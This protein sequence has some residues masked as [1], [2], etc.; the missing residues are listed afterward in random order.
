MSAIA[1]EWSKNE[2]MIIRG[3]FVVIHV[4][5]LTLHEFHFA[6]GFNKD[7]VNTFCSAEDFQ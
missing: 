2:F 5:L 7:F 6:S 3:H 1:H 4:L